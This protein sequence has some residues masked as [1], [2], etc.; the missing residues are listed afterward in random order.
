M[1]HRFPFLKTLCTEEGAT[2]LADWAIN[3]NI[4]NHPDKYFGSFSWDVNMDSDTL[5]DIQSFF[6]FLHTA[7]TNVSTTSLA[8]RVTA[9]KILAKNLR[10][11]GIDSEQG[12]WKTY[13]SRKLKEWQNECR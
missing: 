6:S 3:L 12:Q 13:Y 1:Y 2:E 4:V 5:V 8:Q 7:W 10:A 11:A 9:T